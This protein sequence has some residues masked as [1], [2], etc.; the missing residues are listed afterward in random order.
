MRLGATKGNAETI[1]MTEENRRLRAQKSDLENKLRECDT[2]VRNRVD[3]FIYLP[4]LS[5]F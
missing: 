1:Q 2:Q 5:F 4:F 3:L